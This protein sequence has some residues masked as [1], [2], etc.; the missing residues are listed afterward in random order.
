VNVAGPVVALDT[1]LARIPR[2]GFVSIAR[3]QG[4]GPEDARDAVQEAFTKLL[5]LPRARRVRN[6]EELR[7]LI[8]VLVLNV[9]RNMRRRHFRARPHSVEASQTLLDAKPAADELLVLEQDRQVLQGCLATLD[10]V[11]RKVVSLR[12]ISELPGAEVAKRLALS[13]GHVAVM[14]HRAKKD[15]SNCVTQKTRCAEC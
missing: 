5:E 6:T 10:D 9:A 2:A 15:L 11:Q 12:L 14:L 3:E 13:P 1:L 4:L 8:S 7:A